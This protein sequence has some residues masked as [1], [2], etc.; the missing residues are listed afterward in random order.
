MAVLGPGSG[1]EAAR[2]EAGELE[3]EQV[4]A[5]RH[6]GAAVGNDVAVLGD[7]DLGEAA[8]QLLGRKE[9]AAVIEIGPLSGLER[10]LRRRGPGTPGYPLGATYGRIGA[11]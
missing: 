5:G 4:A 6:P 10:G 8:P 3:G 11:S 2:S 9:L 7:A 1:V